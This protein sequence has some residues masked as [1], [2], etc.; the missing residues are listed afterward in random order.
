[1]AAVLW[2]RFLQPPEPP[3]P[4]PGPGFELQILFEEAVK[5]M[6][7]GKYPVARQRLLEALRRAPEV[8]DLH[9]LMGRCLRAMGYFEASIPHWAWVVERHPAGREPALLELGLALNRMGRAREAVRYL[10]KSF[11]VAPLEQQ[12]QLILAECYLELEL[13]EDALKAVEGWPAAGRAVWVRHRALSYLGRPEEARKVVADMQEEDPGARQFKATLQASLAREEGDF[14][15]ARRSLE[16][17]LRPLEPGGADWARLR[18]SEIALCIET[19]DGARLEAVSDEL[20]KHAEG[21]V[22]GVALWGRA[23]ARLLAGDR[24]GAAAAAREFLERT[25]REFTPLRMERLMMLHLAG[26]LKDEILEAEIRELPRSWQNDLLYYLSLARG[27]RSLA[28]RALQA[29]SGHNF[30]YHAIRRLLAP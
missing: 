23:M 4:P 13:Y 19:G 17:A 5:G 11:E 2:M 16:E 25:D 21:H 20:S 7:E 26:E 14:D 15:A 30:P 24:E 3:L 8:P 27:D 10:E 1:M 12:R 18:R 22:A 6:G 9:F 29:T 28:E